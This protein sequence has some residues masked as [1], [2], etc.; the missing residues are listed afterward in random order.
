MRSE[1]AALEVRRVGL[2]EPVRLTVSVGLAR[3]P[4]EGSSAQELIELA[5][6]RLHDA[7]RA[8]R[9]RVVA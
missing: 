1:I 4:R 6:E 5:R 3:F 9:D 7:K 2:P 8:G